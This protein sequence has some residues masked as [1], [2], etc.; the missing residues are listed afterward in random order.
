MLT[1]DDV[2]IIDYNINPY[3]ECSFAI[4]MIRVWYRVILRNYSSSAK[5]A[6]KMGAQQKE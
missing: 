6:G 2:I 4:I 5:L 3:I 1:R